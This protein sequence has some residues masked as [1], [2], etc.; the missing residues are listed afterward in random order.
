MTKIVE[1][2]VGLG[3][4]G[5]WGSAAVLA[6]SLWADAVVPLWRGAGDV[7]AAI[8]LLFL[9]LAAWSL[10]VLTWVAGAALL[11]RALR[12]RQWTP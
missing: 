2:I 8:G 7:K 3:F 5:V 12:G 10:V 6:Y 4:I 11:T 1:V 9:V